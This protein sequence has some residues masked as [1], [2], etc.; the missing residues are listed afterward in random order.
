MFKKEDSP[1]GLEVYPGIKSGRGYNTYL[2]QGAEINPGN[3]NEDVSRAQI[4]LSKLG[5]PVTVT[6][7]LDPMT[8]K[9]IFD[10]QK[11]VGLL[12]DGH[13]T[14]ATMSALDDAIGNNMV[15]QPQA[16]LAGSSDLPSGDLP[17]AARVSG[18]AMVILQEG[19]A[20]FMWGG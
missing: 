9:V 8:W 3:T 18:S 15:V 13:L 4:I 11:Q 16:V 20:P 10:F 14:P 5:W 12:P 17:R 19:P 6:G 7:T 1:F 2:K